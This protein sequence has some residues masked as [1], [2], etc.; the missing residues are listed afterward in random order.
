MFEFPHGRF[1]RA[2][3]EDVAHF[4]GQQMWQGKSAMTKPLTFM[5]AVH[6]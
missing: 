4:I 5:E 2:C 3:V 1:W 6:I